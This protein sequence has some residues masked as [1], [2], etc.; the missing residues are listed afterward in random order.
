MCCCRMCTDP[1]ILIFQNVVAVIVT[2][3]RW[4]CH[5]NVGYRNRDMCEQHDSLN[6]PGRMICYSDFPIDKLKHS[7]LFSSIVV[8]VFLAA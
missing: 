8:Y 4:P 6:I 2:L 7:T 3:K 5:V 1:K